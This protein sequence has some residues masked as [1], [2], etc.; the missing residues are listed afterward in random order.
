MRRSSCRHRA[1][2]DWIVPSARRRK[3]ASARVKTQAFPVPVVHLELHTSDLPA[4]RALY[5]ELCGW[6][7]EQIDTRDGSYVALELGG[8]LGGGIIGCGTRRAA[9]LPYVE[10]TR[11]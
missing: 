2:D 10:V 4:A 3:R 1:A 9:W 11:I 8:G 5:G 7:A 6:R